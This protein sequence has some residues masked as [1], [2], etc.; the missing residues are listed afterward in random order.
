MKHPM[1]N[2]TLLL[3]AISTTIFAQTPPV[4]KDKVAIGGYDLVSYF[5]EIKPK[6]GSSAIQYTYKGV[7]Y[8]FASAENKAAFSKN[9]EAYLPQYE[10]YCAYAVG[11]QG[12]KVSI[13]P[14][15]YKVT[16]GK[17]YLFYNGTLGFSGGQFN[18][19]EPWLDNEAELIKLS[20]TNWTKIVNKK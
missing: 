8:H 4:G 18:S 6:K 15:T 17:L 19:L 5:N 20:D 12:K 9:P 1:L 13:N 3:L 10:G 2:I 7:H 14:E 16:N 11:K